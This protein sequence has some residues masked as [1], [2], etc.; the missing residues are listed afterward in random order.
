M[1][2][3]RPLRLEDT[4][5][6]KNLSD[7]RISP[8]GDKVAFVVANSFRVD[9][10]FAKSAIWSVPAAGG[11]ST[12]LTFGPRADECPRWSPDGATLAFLSD[13]EREGRRQVHL[14]PVEGGEAVQL[15]HAKG[16]IAAGRGHS[17]MEWSP[18]GRSIAFLATDPPKKKSTDAGDEIEFE[19]HPV[20]TRM[21]IVDIETG[22]TEAVSPEGL[23]V[24][25]FCW[26]PDGKEFAAVVSDLPHETSWYR[27][28]LEAFSSAKGGSARSLH[29]SVRPVGKPAW[30]PDGS[31]VA[32]LSSFWSDRGNTI[33]DVFIVPADGGKAR[34]VTVSHGV[35]VNSFAWSADSTRILTVAHDDGGMGVS[36]VD[37]ATTERHA[38]WSGD[39]VLAG[40]TESFDMNASETMVMVREDSSSPTDLWIAR[41]QQHALEWDRLTDL[42]PHSREIEA[43][44]TK[45]LH[46][47]GADGLEMQGWILLPPGSSAK[48][49]L[50]MVTLVH[51]GPLLAHLN[52]YT[53]AYREQGLLATNGI[54]VFMPNPRGSTG[55]GLEFAESNIGDM[56]GKD[57]EDILAG[58][59][60]CVELGMADP[61]RQGIAGN[62]YGGF[63]A[64][65]AVTQTDRFKAALMR[66]GISDWRTF[67]GK[68][69]I[70]AWDSIFYGDADPWDPDGIFREFSPITH[71]KNA[72][73]PTLIIH[74]EIDRDVPV[75]QAYL[76]HRALTELDVETELVVY[77]R[78]PHGF[79]ERAHILDSTRRTVDWFSER[80]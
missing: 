13:R 24:W 1:P 4:V 71:V 52:R 47:K 33:G 60:H 7:P 49:P 22:V 11:E 46:W 56:G 65:W 28:R 29:R 51:G 78:E 42:N 27:C 68:T 6:F 69:S 50:P 35:S 40:A 55:W 53:P 41:R 63:M 59:D 67:H 64:A 39:V 20:F 77:P 54:A 62:S 23:H 3:P 44:E 12:R 26:S 25:E 32:F 16:S 15:T 5:S 58:I 76:F 43:G 38:L 18:D 10:I 45:S 61:D 31:S 14:L 19:K 75:E 74:G 70:T 72:K 34:D 79:S 80:L 36:D 57:W 21:H 66:A 73:T 8:D 9:T 17:P 2:T 30:S 37:V 48:G